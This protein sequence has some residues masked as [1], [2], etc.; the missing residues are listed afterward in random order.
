MQLIQ[1]AF[2]ET[3]T[4]TDVAKKRKQKILPYIKELFSKRKP[5][6]NCIEFR[7]FPNKVFLLTCSGTLL[8]AFKHQHVK[9]ISFTK[10]SYKQ[11]ALVVPETVSLD[12]KYGIEIMKRGV[13][14][15]QQ[16]YSKQTGTTKTPG[17]V[18]Y[19][20]GDEQLGFGHIFIPIMPQFSQ[21]ARE[22]NTKQQRYFFDILKKCCRNVI[23]QAN[24][25]FVK[26]L[27]I[28]VLGPGNF[29]NIQ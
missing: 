26:H 7:D 23:E 17:E 11:A 27:V 6:G 15:F 16:M 28:P 20:N 24:S 1:G 4:E 19:T 18:L 3:I 2:I 9:D 25:K 5:S 22:K 13:K 12:G 14:G 8:K 10:W 21:H 29:V